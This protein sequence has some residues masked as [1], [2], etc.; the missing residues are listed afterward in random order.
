M[1]TANTPTSFV[2]NNPA[3]PTTQIPDALPVIHLDT[4]VQAFLESGFSVADIQ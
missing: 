1:A 3:D 2:E 4:Q